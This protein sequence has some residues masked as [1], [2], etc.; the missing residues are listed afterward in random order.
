[1]ALV[2]LV[3]VKEYLEITGTDSD[4]LLQG[5]I[6]RLSAWVERYCD[7][8]F[9]QATYTDE[10]HD[11]DGAKALLVNQY[12][13]DSVTSLFDDTL[14][15]FGTETKIAAAD[16]VI[17]KDRGE[18]HLDGLTFQKGLQNVKVTYVAGFA[19]IPIDLQQA[20]LELVAD[21]FRNKE[22]QGIRS[23][24]IGAFRVEYDLSELPQ[25]VRAVLD[26]YRKPKVAA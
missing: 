8:I 11:G 25:E 12:P 15:N 1:M 4:T 24:A 10:K 6:D 2:T 21:R 23:Q 13:I 5:F 26:S 9:L 19:T 17:Y 3:K 14:R 20:V 16:F 7:R 22:S 18:I